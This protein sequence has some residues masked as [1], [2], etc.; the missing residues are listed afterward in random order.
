MWDWL[1][2]F[3]FAL[4][5]ERAHRLVFTVAK[6]LD[7]IGFWHKGPPQIAPIEVWGL[8]FAH[9]IGLAAGLDKNAELLHLWAH[10]GFAFVEVGTVTPRPQPGNP[11]PRLFR[12][13]QDHALLNRMGFNNDGA[14]AIARRL[15]KRP[16]ALRL[17]I[18]IGKNK[19][20][21]LEEAHKDYL[22]A[23]QILYEYGDFFVINV[24][25]PNTPGLRTL[26]NPE[27]LKRIIGTL[28]EHNPQAKPLL[29]KLSPDL[30]E[31]DL[32]TIGHTAREMKIAGFV[33]GNT[34]TQISYPSLGPGGV[35]GRPL[36][37]FRQKL[38]QT[39][40]GFGLP[41]IGSGGILTPADI[42]EV[43]TSGATLVEL[44]T[45]LIYRGPALLREGMRGVLPH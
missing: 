21:P 36:R 28:Q 25:S 40:K 16:T 38:I 17:G 13:P 41:I 12:I 9:P 43:L 27:D 15:E 5:P 3:L 29:L 31:A 42:T 30:A 7:K 22:T 4:P 34:T 39:L 2:P 44:Y 10:L 14:I 33:A 45:G 1:R 35:S 8:H 11:R 26:Q 18:N 37:P 20:T 19:A 24:S 32:R 6:L 23:F